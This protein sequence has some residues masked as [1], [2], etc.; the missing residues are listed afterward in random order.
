MQFTKR[1][2]CIQSYEALK[3]PTYFSDVCVPIWGKSIKQHTQSS[4]RTA[5]YKKK[6]I[7]YVICIVT[8]IITSFQ[9]RNTSYAGYDI[10]K[11]QRQTIHWSSYIHPQLHTNAHGRRYKLT[12]SSS[13]L[14]TIINYSPW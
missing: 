9:G 8:I 1:S 11:R 4:L 3:N 5:D 14:S 2:E 10:N 6:P 13:D 12:I 7:C